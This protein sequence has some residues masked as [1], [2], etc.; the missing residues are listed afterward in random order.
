MAASQGLPYAR[1]DGLS[2]TGMQDLLLGA[3]AA[4]GAEI[5]QILGRFQP[6]ADQGRGLGRKGAG[7]LRL[8]FLAV[9]ARQVPAHRP[10]QMFT[11][12]LGTGEFGP[13]RQQHIQQFV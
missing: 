13:G 8:Q 3:A 4:A 10:H 9:V 11:A 7:R 5:R 12:T 1:E 6:F 2:G